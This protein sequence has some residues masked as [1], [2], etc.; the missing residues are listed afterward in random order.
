[1]MEEAVASGR[2]NRPGFFEDAL[3]RQIYIGADW[4]GPSRASIDPKKES[5]AD[6]QD[7]EIGVKTRK[8]VCMERTGGEWE[9]KHA[10]LVEE[11]AARRADGLN[12]PPSGGGQAN[13][14]GADRDGS[15]DDTEDETQPQRAQR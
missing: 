2:L 4:I 11:E 10:Q 8:Q 14:G 9:T 13:D 3:L 12:A 6:K 15:D 1:M 7:I 5:D